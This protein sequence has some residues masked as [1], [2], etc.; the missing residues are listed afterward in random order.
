VKGNPIRFKDPAG[1]DAWDF[2]MRQGMQRPSDAPSSY[3]ADWNLVKAV[4]RDV[5]I[6]VATYLIPGAALVRT[7]VW[8]G[9]KVGGAAA[10]AV[11]AVAQS[12]LVLQGESGPRRTSGGVKATGKEPPAAAAAGLNKLS[13]GKAGGGSPDL[14][15]PHLRK[16][17][18]ADIHANAPRDANGRPIDPNTGKP[19][20]GKPDVGHKP[21]HEF[22]RAKAAAEAD[23]MT[24]KEFNDKMNNPKLYQLEDPSSNRSHKFE[25]KP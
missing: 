12:A 4:A 1:L 17:T 11:A 9:Q 21:G 20:Q 25:K 5:A 3:R 2:H 22:R 23:G 13:V 16:G 18:R 7:A 15:R 14:H 24:Q 6:T 10:A 19:I 8:V